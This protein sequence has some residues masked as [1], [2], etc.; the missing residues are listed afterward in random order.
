MLRIF[1]KNLSSFLQT[2]WHVDE[3][4]RKLATHRQTALNQPRNVRNN[5]IRLPVYSCE[6]L[7]KGIGPKLP[8]NVQLMRRKGTRE[9]SSFYLAVSTGRETDS[10]KGENRSVKVRRCIYD[11]SKRSRSKFE[12]TREPVYATSLTIETRRWVKRG[13]RSERFFFESSGRFV[14]SFATVSPEGKEIGRRCARLT[15]ASGRLISCRTDR[16]I[17]CA[18][19]S[20]NRSSFRRKNKELERGNGSWE[21]INSN[22]Q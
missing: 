15:F 13:E 10:F 3:I 8:S 12:A 17:E 21:Q 14:Y 7:T 16:S 22:A 11:E 2:V 5:F 9:F 4:S 19:A 1:T 6:R 18:A 20:K